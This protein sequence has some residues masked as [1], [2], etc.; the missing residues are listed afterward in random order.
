MR[1]I[2]A[3]LLAVAMFGVSAIPAGARGNDGSHHRSHCHRVPHVRGMVIAESGQTFEATWNTLIA[4]LEAN[5]NINIVAT[6]DHA[7][8]A[9][10]AGLDLEPNR[11][12]V[13]GN[14]ALGTPVMIAGRTAGLDLPQKMQVWEDHHRVFVGYN[15]VE[16][17]AA[18]HGAGDATT[19]DT[20]AAAL[21]GLTATATGDHNDCAQK[22]HQ[23]RGLRRVAR[24]PGIATVASD[25]DFD[26]TWSRLLGAIEASPASVAFTVDHGANS[27]GTLPPTRL[28][29][30]GNPILG[31]PLMQQS[32]TAGIDL[33][34]KILVWEDADGV[35]QVSTTDVRFLKQRH[36]LRHVR[37]SLTAIDGAISN[38]VATATSAP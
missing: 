10:G 7:A 14:P 5:P 34:L 24:R 25:A 38:F 32:P 27:G 22:R 9:A 16:Y 18:R 30:F 28:V 37:T 23:N 4:A 21:A 17:L 26:T 3:V 29:V 15:S 6:I 20:I 19:L 31:T 1:L 2:G 11:V 36:R 12:V 8:A 35:T 13:F 33:P